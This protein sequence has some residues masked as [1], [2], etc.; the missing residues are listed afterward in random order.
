M[1]TV[2]VRVIIAVL[3]VSPPESRLTELPLSGPLQIMP[4]EEKEPGKVHMT[5]NPSPWKGLTMTLLVF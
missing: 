1:A 5:F 4:E 2:L 3:D